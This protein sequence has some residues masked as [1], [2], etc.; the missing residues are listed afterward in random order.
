M[1]QNDHRALCLFEVVNEFFERHLGGYIV[2]FY[3]TDAALVRQFSGLELEQ[4]FRYRHIDVYRTASVPLCCQQRLVHQA[5]AV[6]PFIIVVRLG[7]RDGTFHETSE[8]IRL[9]QRL[10]VELV[11]PLRRTVGRNDY[12]RLFPIECL[13]HGRQ[14][15]EQCRA[16]SDTNG[17]R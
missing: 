6:P 14:K 3:Q 12:Q 17:N 9:R 13:C 15:I 1:S 7:Q 10:S 8:G 2:F 4:R 5:V 11:N 16:R